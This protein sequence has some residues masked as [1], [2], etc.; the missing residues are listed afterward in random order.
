MTTF[1]N[2]CKILAN[3]WL[4]SS[5]QDFTEFFLEYNMGFPIAFGIAN[6]IILDISDKGVALV[7]ETFTAFLSLIGKTDTGFASVSDLV[8]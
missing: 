3:V 4:D 7:E 8:G 2:K 6:D 1:E 5:E